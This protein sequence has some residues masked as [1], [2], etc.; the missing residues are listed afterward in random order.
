MRVCVCVRVTEAVTSMSLCHPAKN[1][2]PP[3]GRLKEET[4]KSKTL[5]EAGL[6]VSFPLVSI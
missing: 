2:S 5:T 4:T 1:L 6:F 3:G